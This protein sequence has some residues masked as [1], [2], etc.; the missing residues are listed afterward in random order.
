MLGW[1]QIRASTL[2]KMRLTLVT[3]RASQESGREAPVERDDV[4]SD[5]PDPGF[6]C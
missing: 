3:P 1:A 5:T 6:T 4:K 2:A